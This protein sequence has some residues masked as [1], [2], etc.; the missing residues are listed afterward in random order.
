MPAENN[1]TNHEAA[2]LGALDAVGR[3]EDT[4]NTFVIVFTDGT[5]T[6]GYDH[7]SGSP[8]PGLLDSHSYG[9]AEADS[10]WYSQFSQWAL[11]DAQTLKDQ[12]PVYAVGYGSEIKNDADCQAFIQ[13][14]SSGEEY[15]IDTRLEETQDIGSIFQAIYSDLCWKAV[16]VKVT[17]YISEYWDVAE[18]ELPMGCKVEKIPILNQRGEEDTI[19]KLTFPVTREMGADD[20]ESFQIPVVLREAYREV[21]EPTLYETN[22]DDPFAKDVE[23]TGA[24]VTYEDENG[25]EQKVDV[26]SPELTVYPNFAD[27][28][29]E[30][31]ALQKQAKAENRRCTN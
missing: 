5:T 2:V 3:L 20:Q 17:D 18:E 9:M 14:L 15:Y 30:K 28:E 19:T 11:D 13:N 16:K 7:S 12:V 8:D 27:Y 10:S 29:L 4:G 22:Q 24:F 23:G 21:Q 25:N 31:E 1:G 26:P 6:A